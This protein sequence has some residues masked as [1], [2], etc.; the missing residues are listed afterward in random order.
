MTLRHAVVD[1][2]ST[3]PHLRMP[4]WVADHVHATV[5]DGWRA[6]VIASPAVALG[7]WTNPASDETM[8]AV[9]DAE[10]YFGYGVPGALVEAAPL[11]RWTHSM[12]A[13][14]GGTISPMMRSRGLMFTNNAGIYG[15][16][17]ADT[18]LGGVLHFLRGLDLAVR[19]QAA[20]VW[21]QTTFPAEVTRLREVDECRVLVL[22]AGGIGSSVAKRFSALGCQCTG[23]RRRP[24]L[25]PLPGFSRVAGPDAIEAELPFAD[26][27]VVAAPATADTNELL[28]GPRLALLPA[29]AI[30]VNV[31]RG[32]LIAEAA[33]R[34]A[35]DS[36]HVR[37]AVLDV[38]Q[39]E[40][41]PVDSGWWDH[42]RVLIT[43]HVSGV[44]PRRQWTRALEL[45][46]DNWRRWV[47]GEPLRNV[48]DL[49]AGY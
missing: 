30:V 20:H 43:P 1:L 29:G 40:P 38:F 41:L 15:E 8:A 23:I 13:G 27:V 28:D 31:A 7:S 25:G 18:V 48:V 21:D 6:T 17:I 5:P 26:V 34:A 37:G 39:T 14:V 4:D 33:L 49:D 19:Q 47:A 42:P 10:V 22:G 2:R 9:V 24:E 44:A 12:A 32:S 36:G 16:S 46:D 3:V 35:L 45:F 11:L